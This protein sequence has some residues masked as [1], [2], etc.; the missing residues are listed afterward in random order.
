MNTKTKYAVITGL[1][2]GIMIGH[3]ADVKTTGYEAYLMAK[4]R[5]E[6]DRIDHIQ[7][8]LIQ[9]RIDSLEAI[10]TREAIAALLEQQRQRIISQQQAQQQL[11]AQQLRLQRARQQSHTVRGDASA[12]QEKK[13]Q[14]D[15]SHIPAGKVRRYVARFHSTAVAEQAKFGIPASIK[16]AQGILESNS[17]SSTLSTKYHNDFGIKCHQRRCKRGHCSRHNDDSPNDRFVNFQTNWF[18]WRAHSYLLTDNQR[19]AAIFKSK[20]SA[21]PFTRYATLPGRNYKRNGGWWY[22]T[23][24]NFNNKLAAMR[25]NWNVPYKRFAYGLDLVG[26]ATSNRY[27]E[28]LIDLIEKYNLHQYDAK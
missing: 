24:P 2:V 1:F 9:V 21:K 12:Y 6:E 3:Y 15:F 8:S 18:S 14:Q 17:G 28:S 13:Q 26:Y 25:D 20:Y 16:L 10:E 4:A 23:D 5:A 27:A 19:Y 7:D 22:G 11:A